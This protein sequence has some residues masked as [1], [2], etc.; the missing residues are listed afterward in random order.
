MDVVIP[1]ALGKWPHKYGFSFKNFNGSFQK[2]LMVKLFN[3]VPE[4][5]NKNRTKT[6]I[7]LCKIRDIL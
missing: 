7:Q 5:E 6:K 2:T 3:L 4:K 1:A